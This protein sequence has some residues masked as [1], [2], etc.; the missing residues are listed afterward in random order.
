MRELTAS[1][2]DQ[3]SGG[4]NWTEV[5][6]GVG[7]IALG[8]AIVGTAG[9]ATIPVGLVGAATFGE[10]GIGLTGLTLSF[11]GGGLMG[12]GSRLMQDV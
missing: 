12:H 4:A 11:C 5:G 3:V 1:E 7:A 2:I 8:V 9:L 10:I 6:V